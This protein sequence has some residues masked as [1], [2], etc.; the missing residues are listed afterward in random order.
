MLK[1][2]RRE[3]CSVGID[4]QRGGPE[5][6]AEPGGGLC[7]RGGWGMGCMP[8]GNMPGKPSFPPATSAREL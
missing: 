5:K 4:H 8:M 3:H 1:R 7:L 6:E 2:G